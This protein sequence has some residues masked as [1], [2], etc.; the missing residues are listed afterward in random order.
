MNDKHP[1]DLY[2][3]ARQQ[4]EA[5]DKAEAACLLCQAL[6]CEKVAPFIEGSIE[7]LLTPDTAAH[8]V[9]LMLLGL[10]SERQRR[11]GAK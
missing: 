9:S 7:E 1:I 5:G 8:R 3:Q 11:G 2:Y 6:G 10:E 4:F